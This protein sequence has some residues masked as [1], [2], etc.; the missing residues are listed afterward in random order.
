M[1]NKNSVGNLF[2][3]TRTLMLAPLVVVLAGCDLLPSSDDDA[4]VETPVAGVETPVAGVEFSTLR[5][6]WPAITSKIAIDDAMEAEIASLLVGMSLAEKIGQMTQPEIKNITAGDVTEYHLGSVLNGGGSWPGNIKEAPLSA[7]LALADTYWDE[8]MDATDGNAAIPLIWGTDAVHGHSNVYGATQFPH[9]IGLGAANDPDLIRRIGAATAEE[10]AATG[11]DWTFAPTLAVVRDDRW[12]RTYEGYSEDPEIVF[13]FAGAMVDG[14]QGEFTQSN[15][16]ATAKHYI[17]DGGTELGADQGNNSASEA[18]M[19]NIHGQGYYSA[20]EAGVQTVMASFNSWNDAKLHGDEFLLN[21]VL[22]TKMGFDGF[23]VSDWDGIGQVT[24]CTNSSCA[25]AINAGV[26]MIMVPKEWKAFITNTIAQVDDGTITE[27]R[28]NDAVT[29]ILRVKM[30]AGMFEHPKPSLRALAGN[31]DMVGSAAHRAIAREAVRKSLVLLKNSGSILPLSAAANILVVGEA[32]NSMEL[33]TGGWT[34]GWQGT[35][36]SNDDFPNGAT[37]YAGLEAAVT[38][39]GGTIAYSSDGSIADDTYDVVIV[40]LG[41][42]PYAEGQ[43]DISKFQTLEFSTLPKSQGDDAL[44]TVA[45]NVTNTPIL[46]LYVGGRPLWMNKE[47]NQS[48]AF[49]AAWLPGSEGAGVADVLFGDFEFTGKLSFSWPATD[50]QVSVN[51]NDS[52]TPLFAYGFGLTTTDVDTLSSTLA[53]AVSDSGCDAPTS[54]TG[55]TNTPIGIFENGAN[56]NNHLMR[57]GSGG[58]WN[59][60]INMDPNVT[61]TSD[62]GAITVDVVNGA[63]IQYGAFDVTWAGAGQIYAQTADEA[64][65]DRSDYVNSA[66]SLKFKMKVN[67]APTPGQSVKLQIHCVHPC[68]AEIEIFDLVTSVADGGW[69]EISIPLQCFI[70]S[71]LDYTKVN[72]PFLMFAEA[73]LAISLESIRWEPNTAGDTP[74]CSAFAPQQDIID[75]PNHLIF[76]DALS[77]GYSFGNYN[78][79]SGAIAD[80]GTGTNNAFTAELTLGTNVAFKKDGLPADLSAYLATGKLEF[81]VFFTAIGADAEVMVKMATNWPELGD[82]DLFSTLLGFT[83]VV[84]T[85]YAVEVPI[86]MLIAN[87]NR[88]APGSAL[89]IVNV[90]DILVLEA[91]TAPSTIYVDNV[92]LTK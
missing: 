55:T 5:T 86:A 51:R 33:Q 71:G 38:A 81:E 16:V 46:T 48:D 90:T 36:N 82:V 42:T 7:W 39:A 87:G 53:V 83:P 19:I 70:D 41:E 62:G 29:R 2:S 63:S 64:G 68:V 13:N 76:D 28:I 91:L 56:V 32:A 61:T 23:V 40:A 57:V 74:D 89:D 58:I 21:Q 75:E 31:A 8:S 85:W 26:D 88:F 15:V 84:N 35:G 78:N 49:V 44:T 69:H 80:D 12:G 92:R 67:T 47:I 65:I 1:S 77:T 11:I 22:K 6:D 37:I 20:L 34:L 24:G 52:E 18:D 10:V 4:A 25:Q 17:G 43:G 14:L 60:D 30:R 50:C 59:Q 72:T 9:N 79:G 66:T 73:P 3:L 27:A 54:G 45:A